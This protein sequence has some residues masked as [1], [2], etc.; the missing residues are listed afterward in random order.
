M[1]DIIYIIIFIGMFGIP[2]LGL[3][4]LEKYL[5]KRGH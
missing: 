3:N 1:E 2:I 4:V 5:T